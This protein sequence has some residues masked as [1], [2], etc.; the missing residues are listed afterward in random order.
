MGRLCIVGLDCLTP[1]LAFDRFAGDMPTLSRLRSEGIYGPLRSCVPPITVPAWACMT[2]GFSPSDLG[3]YGFRNPARG[4]YL[5]RTLANSLSHDKPYLWDTLSEFNKKS[6]VLSVPLTWPAR[7]LNGKMVTGFLTPDNREHASY[8]EGELSQLEKHLGPL[9]FDVEGFRSGHCEKIQASA[10]RLSEQQTAYFCHWLQNENWDFAMRVDMGPDRMHHAFWGAMMER[11]DHP[12]GDAMQEYYRA[13]DRQLAQVMA[14][15]TP[16]DTLMV[17]SDHGA[18]TMVGTVALNQWL[19]DEGFL[20]LRTPPEKGDGL[21]AQN[22]DW[23]NTQAFA[24]GGYVGRI[25]VNLAG[26]EPEGIVSPN[27]LEPLLDRLENSLSKLKTLAGEPLR[28]RALRH[29]DLGENP[30]GL[31]PD[32]EL[33]LESFAYRALGTMGYSTS[34]GCQND[35][36]E[37]GA[38]HALHGLLVMTG[39]SVTPRKVKKASL[40]DIAPTVYSHFGIEPNKD[41][42]G[43]AIQA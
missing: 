16:E 8:P 41:W 28:F 20:K 26:R 13:V 6:L 34:V 37:D 5:E 21:D 39:P 32:L 27:E 4:A 1:E 12:F 23:K 2:T 25:Y 9:P 24:A 3:I 15:L 11:G 22:V 29:R 31:P 43:S 10:L 30:Q 14:C 33:E 42:Q 38:N 40:F 7:P 35:I 17:V 18:Q 19:L 36:G